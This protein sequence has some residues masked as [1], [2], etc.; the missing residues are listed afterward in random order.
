MLGLINAS[1]RFA[2]NLFPHEQLESIL[3]NPQDVHN[4]IIGGILVIP[5]EQSM[6]LTIWGIKI[7]VM[8]F[9]YRLT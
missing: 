5:L 3:A 9:I 4:R 8:G 7:C 6:L 1:G 2:T